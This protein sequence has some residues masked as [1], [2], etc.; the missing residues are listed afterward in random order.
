MVIIR[1]QFTIQAPVTVVA[2]F[3]RDT[4]VLKKLT[5]PP[6]IVQIHSIEPL[7]EDSVSVFT[8]WFGP[9]PLHWRAVHSSVDPASGFTDT[10]S[11]GPMAAWRHHHSWTALPGGA[12]E[13]REQIEY[14]HKPGLPGLLTRILFAPPMLRLMLVYR[15]AVM[16]RECQR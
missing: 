3:H 15:R 10:L 6:V 11:G 8:L 9:L 5:P 13:M 2:A 12:T 14:E 16:R 7:A 1:D 4:T